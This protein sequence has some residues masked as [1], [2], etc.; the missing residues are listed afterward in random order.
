VTKEPKNTSKTELI[1]GLPLS[2]VFVR[3]QKTPSRLPLIQGLAI[4]P[5]N[6]TPIHL[7]AE[8]WSLEPVNPPLG[9]KNGGETQILAPELKILKM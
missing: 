8:L 3:P 4:A 5:L 6:S 2:P 7:V 9:R 1:T